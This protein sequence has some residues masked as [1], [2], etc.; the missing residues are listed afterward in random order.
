[1]AR[2]GVA[3]G[4]KLLAAPLVGLAIALALGFE[5]AAVA[6]TFVLLTAGPT[7]VTP[8]ILVGAFGGDNDGSAASQFVSTSVSVTTL[9][10]VVTVTL[11]VA[12]LQSGL[13]L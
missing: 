8:V 3:S 7:A 5:N 1:M 9:A 12:A 6:R 4:V 13:V 10:S 2:V 11:L